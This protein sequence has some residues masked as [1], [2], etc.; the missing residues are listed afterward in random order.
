MVRFTVNLIRFAINSRLFLFPITKI[1]RKVQLQLITLLYSVMIANVMLWYFF[2]LLELSGD[3]EFI[4]GPK[5]DSSQSFSIC[6]WNLISMS[7]HNYSNISLLT[8]YIFIHDFD[9]ICLSET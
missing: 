7:A 3:V 5:P 4:P 1:F 2:R 6:Q 8:A 9:I